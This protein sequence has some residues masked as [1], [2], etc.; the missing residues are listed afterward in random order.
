MKK[1]FTCISLSVLA[2]AASAQ[3]EKGTYWLGG[4]LGFGSRKSTNDYQE[5]KSS[6]FNSL[7]SVAKATKPNKFWGVYVGYDVYNNSNTYYNPNP[8]FSKTE[9]RSVSLG[10]FKQDYYNI[11]NNWYW[12]MNYALNM[13][14]NYN[15]NLDTEDSRGWNARAGLTPGIAYQLNKNFILQ[16]SMNN[17]FQCSYSKTKGNNFN[18]KSESFSTSIQ[19]PSISNISIGIQWLIP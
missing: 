1:M 5:Q 4:N 13:G 17:I 3:I 9:N 10:V 18:S 14:L 8:S 2:F 7:L 11:K 15:Y 12:F 19:L 6:N 16:T